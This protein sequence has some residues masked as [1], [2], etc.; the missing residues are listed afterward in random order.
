MNPSPSQPVVVIGAGPAGLTAAIQLLELGFPVTVLEK[1]PDYVGGIA[2]T[3]CYQGYRFDIGGH[4][5]FSKNPEIVEWW[6]KRLGND[7]ISVRRLS[8]IF[9]RGRFFD[10]PLSAVNA[11]RGLGIG[12]SILCM[13]SYFRSRLFPITPELSF[14]DWVNNRFGRKLFEI[15]FK[16]Y[17]EKVWGIPCS[18]LSADWAAQR[19]KGLSL[20]EAV[21][22]ALLP[23]WLRGNPTVKTLIDSF[24][25]PRFGPGMMWEKTRDD[26]R[27]MGGKVMMGRSVVRISHTQG[28]INSVTARL[29][30]GGEE[31]YPASFVISSMPL[32]DG[33]LV[34]QPEVTSQAREAAS[35]LQY[36]D[37]MT[38]ALIVNRIGLFPDNWIYVHDPAVKMGRIQNINNW[39]L[40]MV[41]NSQTTCLG[42]EYF[43]F[44]GDSLWN[45]PDSELIQLGKNELHQLQLVDPEEVIGGC[46]V[47]MEKAYP[48]YYPGYQHDIEIIREALNTIENLQ[49]IGRNGMHKYNNQD[50]SMMTALLA[51]RNLAGARYDVWKVNSDAQYQEEG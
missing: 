32:R 40:E 23:R 25:Y 18:H 30:Q 45:A 34:L 4:R 21:R 5:F 15:F 11:L 20:A 28:K 3:V 8:R 16:S 2:R 44:A 47:R 17:T 24:Q 9:Y 6:Q 38:V 31:E 48:I 10:Y 41:A 27:Q 42:L 43:C 26:I 51:A 19:I 37:F 14:A 1:D 50:H 49:A 46:V 39:S 36:R 35:R 22:N 29:P 12:T 7:L 13:A 33:L